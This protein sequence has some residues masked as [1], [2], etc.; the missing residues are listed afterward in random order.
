MS[1]L[2]VQDANVISEK[3]IAQ[4]DKVRSL[5]S[6][7]ADKTVI[8]AEVK[9]LLNLKAE[10]KAYTGVEWK[11]GMIPDKIA[12][13]DKNKLSE[14]IIQQEK[15]IKEL[16][17]KI[18]QEMQYLSNLKTSY[19]DK[20]GS[21]WSGANENIAQNDKLKNSHAEKLSNEIKTQ[22]DK[23]RELKKSQAD[24]S[25]IDVE[26]KKLLTLKADYKSIS[27]QDW[28]QSS[29]STSKTPSKTC[30]NVINKMT[31][32]E[33]ISEE[34]QK[35][36]DK[37]RQLKAAKAEKPIIDQ[38]V[39]LL[40]T[41][42]ADY[43]TATGKDWKP[44]TTPVANVSNKEEYKTLTGQEWK[45][46]K[47]D[48]STKKKKQENISKTEKQKGTPNKEISKSENTK[49][50]DTSKTGTR[51]GLEAKKAEN[52]F[53]WY[54]QLI[55]KSGMIEYYDVSGCYIFRPWSFSVWKIIKGYIDAEITKLGVQECYFPMFVTRSVL[56]KEKTHIADF[57]PEVAWVTK[58]GESDLAEP[59][60]IRP[61]SETVMYPAYAKWLR[62]DTELPLRLNQWNNVV[63]N[64]IYC[65]IK[66]LDVIMLK[67]S[68]YLYDVV[69]EMGV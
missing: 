37:I 53:E 33:K 35:Q 13:S 60:A 23:V 16:Q 51:L 34:I 20:I 9:I 27:G 63:V 39:K 64:I 44:S 49:G 31:D 8:D 57:A 5:K 62:S 10:Y 1:Q 2:E 38:E 29:T 46:V 40:L 50:T 17:A 69:T 6:Q 30:D 42:K 67:Q 55:T 66:K 56:E 25:I 14:D 65:H 19:K 48:T 26:I 32:H 15:K 12:P 59:I 4:G 18:N 61:T 47:P 43:K 68:I 28:K 36:G 45:S 52:F 11:P 7:K 58:C 21:D 54:S 22:G 41:L 24:K 3:I